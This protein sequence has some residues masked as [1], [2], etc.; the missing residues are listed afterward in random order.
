MTIRPLILATGLALLATPVAGASAALPIKRITAADNGTEVVLR[1]QQ[2][3]TIRLAANAS[4]GYRWRLRTRPDFEVVRIEAFRY[5]QPKS[6]G[7]V[8][9]T[10]VPG[11]QLYV[12]RG[13]L[14]GRTRLTA[15]YVAPGTGAV[16]RRFSVRFRVPVPA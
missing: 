4:T 8:P 16:V 1:A 3:A 9:M 7:D 10:G 6:E 2:Q 12:L 13:A 5:E 15:E 14:A 11:R